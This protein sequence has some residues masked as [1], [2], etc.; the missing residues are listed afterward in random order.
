MSSPVYITGAGIV[1]A[2]G[3]GLA[4]TAQ[5]LGEGRCGLAP[6]RFLQT[7]HREF[8][9]GE[10]PLSNA[11]M[12]ERL[13]IASGTPTTRCVLLG[14]MALDEAI[15][16]ARI[17]PDMLSH[18]AFISGST[19]GG[20]D[21]SEN[22][23][24]D[25]LHSDQDLW[26]EYIALHDVGT[27]TTRIADYGGHFGYTA[28]LS[29]ACSSAANALLYGLQ[30][31][32]SGERDLVIAGGTESL[33]RFHL[34]G[35]NALLILDHAPCRPFCATRAGLNLGE[36]A[37]YLV[38]E[39][40]ESARRR[41]ATPLALFSGGGNA[42]DAFHQT[43][44]SPEAEGPRRAMLAALADAGLQPAD[45]GY[46]NAHGTGTPDNDRSEAAALRQVFG[47]ALPPYSSTKSATGHTTSASGAI[48]AAVCLLALRDGLL[49]A[50]LN[51]R[52]PIEGMPAPVTVPQ[53]GARLKH[54]LCN[55]F[56]FGG[57]DSALVFS[58]VTGT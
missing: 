22:H 2:L 7:S 41:H 33:T 50:N 16:S 25:F 35:F 48:E 29:T 42:C 46:V 39:S 3:T 24:Q 36:G 37:A 56:G 4:T 27:T 11:A 45:I 28:S 55:S 19:V 20:M 34:N 58:Q 47:S 23:Y 9:V 32:R 38:L 51:W 21:K 57:N 54:V 49:P 40:A 31:I 30:L 13:G 6:P 8:P 44:T 15:R 10:V 5:A 1:S 12:M 17:S 53:H 43:A 18:A 52:S 14:Q 26:N